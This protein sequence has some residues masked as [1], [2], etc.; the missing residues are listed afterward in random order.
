MY[1]NYFSVKFRRQIYYTTYDNKIRSGNINVSPGVKLEIHFSESLKSLESFFDSNL[2]NNMKYIASID[3]TN[4]DASLVTSFKRL[5][6]G[7]D[8]LISVNFT[9]IDTSNV[10]N[11]ESMFEGCS[12][13]L[14]VNLS[15]FKTNKINNAQNMLK[16][17]ISIRILDIWCGVIISSRISGCILQ[18]IDIRVIFITV[19]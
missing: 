7:C 13:L 15:Q 2:H 3:F 17:C 8:S 1:I 12:S 10:V 4:F 18:K 14:S 9:N 19:R 6:Y 16:G 5:F 11:M